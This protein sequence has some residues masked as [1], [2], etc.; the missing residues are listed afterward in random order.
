MIGQTISHY[1]IVEHLGAGGMGVVYKAQDVKLGRFAALKFL[2]PDFSRDPISLQRFQ[3]EARAASALNHPNICTVYEIDEYQGQSFIAMEFLDGQTLKH[4]PLLQLDE[5][6]KILEI[7]IQV[8]DA[9]DAAHC[10]GVIHRDIKPANVFVTRRGHAKLLDFGLA[11]LSRTPAAAAAVGVSSAE[12]IGITETNLT[13]AGMAVGTIAYMSPEQALGEPLDARTDLFSFGAVLYEVAAGRPPF[14]GNTSAAIFDAILHKIPVSPVRLNPDMPDELEHI[15]NKLLEKDRD[16]RYQSAKDVATDLRR[17]KRDTDSGHPTQLTRALSTRYRLKDLTGRILGIGTASLG[18]ALL[19]LL[20]LYLLPGLNGRIDSIA[21]M[22][23]VNATSDAQLEYLSDGLTESLIN[24]VSELPTLSV[25]SRNS[26]FRYKGKGSDAKTLGGELGVRA[27]LLGRVVEQGDNLSVSVELVDTKNNRHLW[28]EQYNRKISDLASVQPDIT[29]AISETLKLKLNG[30]EKSRL[31]KRP[32]ED[33]VAYQL[34]LNGLYFWNKGTEDGFHRAENLFN[35]AIAKDP[36]FALAQAGLADTYGL[37]ADSGYLSPG[38]AWPRA[39][40]AATI[41]VGIEDSLAEGH[42]SL[43]LVKAYYDWDWTG[44]EKDFQHAIELNPNSAAAH[45]WYGAFLAKLGRQN[46]AQREL[47]KARELDPLSLLISTS[48]GWEYYASGQLDRAIEQLKKTLE[49]D[50]AYGPAR[51]L[52]EV[53]YEQ[54]GMFKEAVAEWQKTFTL[55][56]NPELAA[57]IGD[58]FAASGYK[59]VLQDWLEGLQELSKREYVS[60]YEVAGV[61]ARL[62]NREQAF[63][64]LEKAYAGRDSG[65]VALNVEPVF[66]GLRSDPRLQNLVKRVGLPQ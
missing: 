9:L 48:V 16:E 26:V 36:K 46:E 54:K 39:K 29:R 51:R 43:A 45:H 20:S 57:A 1:R 42:T 37:M 55:A 7:G 53:C 24:S 19:V 34:Y 44:A 49:I 62:G 66:Q 61:Y 63:S 25:M 2:P 27:V 35:Q 31:A 10:Q 56:N 52:L 5:I 18:V 8:A 40:T 33:P 4:K 15:I 50:Q 32:T 13:S 59:A 60:P 23:F 14:P 12:T 65:I 64:W 11:K 3:L 28:G 17:L 58:D 41:A 22:P 47:Q 21:V 6:D 30:E 38:E